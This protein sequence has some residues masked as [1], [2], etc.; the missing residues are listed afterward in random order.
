MGWGVNIT[1]KARRSRKA[2]ASGDI[3]EFFAVR[4]SRP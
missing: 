4:K 2:N 1:M 3:D